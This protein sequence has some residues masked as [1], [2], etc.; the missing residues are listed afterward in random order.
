MKGLRQKS[1]QGDRVITAIM[2]SLGVQSEFS[3]DGVKLLKCDH[4]DVIHIDFSD[5]PDL[6]QTVAVACAAKGVR[7]HLTGLESLRIKETDRIQALQNELGKLGAK[8]EEH[9][10]EWLL[11][12]SPEIPKEVHIETYDDHRMAMAFAPL[13]TRLKLNIADGD[14]VAK[15]YPNFWEHMQKAGFEIKQ[16]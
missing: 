4:D 12:P 5:C 6:A 15:S 9:K 1:F 10:G 2:K 14:V 16:G 11:T 13:A 7:C 3:D 8:M